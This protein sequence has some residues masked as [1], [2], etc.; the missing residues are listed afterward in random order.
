[1]APA[2]QRIMYV[3]GKMTVLMAAMRSPAQDVSGFNLLINYCLS[4][5]LNTRLVIQIC[6]V[7]LSALCNV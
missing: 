7:S 2:S 6:F 1:M 4:I 5:E 3:M